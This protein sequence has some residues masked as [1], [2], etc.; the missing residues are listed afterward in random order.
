MEAKIAVLGR[1]SRKYLRI[2]IARGTILEST[3]APAAKN[4][5][6]PGKGWHSSF[7]GFCVTGCG[8]KSCAN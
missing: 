6:A 2:L 8:E 7:P 1:K 4:F 5:A 3:L